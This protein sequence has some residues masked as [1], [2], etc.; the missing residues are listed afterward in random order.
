RGSLRKLNPTALVQ[1]A[2]A[3]II[4]GYL[5]PLLGLT[6]AAFLAIDIALGLWQRRSTSPPAQPETPVDQLGGAPRE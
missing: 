6:L 2:A 1:V 4:A 5:I 3:V